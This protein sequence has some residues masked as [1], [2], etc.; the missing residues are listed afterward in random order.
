MKIIDFIRDEGIFFIFFILLLL[1]SILF[2]GEIPRY[3]S[4][5]D[6][7]TIIALSALLIIT[8][9]LKESGFLRFLSKQILKKF[10]NEREL[11]IAFVLLSALLSMF[12]INDVTLFII[13]PLS[14]GLQSEVK[15]DITKLVI[16][17]AL[18]VNV[19]SLLTP[20]G[21][22]QNLLLWYKWEISFLLFIQKM[23]PL[24]VLLLSLLLIFTF[25]TF[26]NKKIHL[27]TKSTTNSKP[28]K[29]LFYY[30]L[31][32]LLAF[33]FSLELNVEIYA[34]IFVFIFYVLFY[35][36]IVY[37]TDWLLVLLFIVIFIDFHIISTI[38]FISKAVKAA[39]LNSSGNV[40][41]LSAFTS[42]II[43]NVPATTF[44][45]KFSD[46]YLAIAYGVN[47]GGNGLI[48]ASL[49]NIIAM[50]IAR[51]KSWKCFHKYSIPYFVVSLL[52]AY[53]LFF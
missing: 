17:E 9:G 14:L 44:L 11:A 29:R 4:F 52:G 46:N 41:L 20:I 36:Q 21:N 3:F 13:V 47:V 48:I 16:F 2:P 18:A 35:R 10:E 15:N 27:A 19:G 45:S 6:W 8:T 25:T 23:L 43:S 1:L 51:G 39:N 40:Y 50:R 22:P 32:I 28:N 49:A 34:L 7:N 31:F 38:P 42:Q 12:L 33:I 26:K 37:R 5:I 24:G 30:S 53:F